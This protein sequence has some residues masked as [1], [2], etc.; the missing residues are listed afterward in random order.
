[1]STCL[2]E[3]ALDDLILNDDGGT[4]RQ[5]AS[6]LQTC[7]DCRQRYESRRAVLEQFECEQAPAFWPKTRR[8]YLRRRGTRR[9]FILGIPCGLAA[10]CAF[11]FLA[12]SGPSPTGSY[13]AAKGTAALEIHCRRGGRTF[14]LHLEDRV[15]PGD[16]LR[17]VPRPASSAVHFVQ[18]ASIDGTGRFTPF[19]PSSSA[20]S[21]IP[22]PSPG[23]P[24]DGSI[25]LDFAPGPERLI[26]IFS[27][28]SLSVSQVEQ[29]A[30][31]HLADLRP[32]SDIAGV[33]SG[34]IVLDKTTAASE[35]P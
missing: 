8:G 23:Q 26:F 18:V 12:R 10:A 17:F 31:Q 33:E 35:S 32:L 21:S 19:Y 6:H 7:D 20:A 14:P 5:A 4:S 2:S 11:A 25:R 9:A 1:M 29:T 24:L 3:F 16:E 22:L 28:E 27:P 15:E 13:L 34:W 30:R